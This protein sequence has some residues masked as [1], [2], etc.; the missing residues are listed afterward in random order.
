V[1]IG[2][3]ISDGAVVKAAILN[4]RALV[5]D[6]PSG[7]VL[8]AIV[9]ERVGNKA[10]DAAPGDLEVAVDGDVLQ[11]TAGKQIEFRCGKSKILL[12]KD[13]RIHI[14]GSYVISASRGP[15]KIKGATIALN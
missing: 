10:R 9:R 1:A 7:P 13:G 11:F 5:L 15:N 2:I 14:S 3:P 8:I 12:R 4:R 6:S